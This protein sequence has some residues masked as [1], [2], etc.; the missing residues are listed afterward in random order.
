MN[1]IAIY[2]LHIGPLSLAASYSFS[3]P[4]IRTERVSLFTDIHLISGEAQGWAFLGK[5]TQGCETREE[6]DS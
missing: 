5:K 6:N 3:N 4:G 2:Y 1:K